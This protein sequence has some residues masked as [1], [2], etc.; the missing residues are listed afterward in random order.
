[1]RPYLVSHISESQP[2]KS[3]LKH[4]SRFLN[5]V[6]ILLLLV[7]TW[8]NAVAATDRRVLILNS[9]HQG[10]TWGDNETSG[11]LATLASASFKTHPEIEYLDTK[12][13]PDQQHFPQLLE[14]YRAKNTLSRIALVLTLDDPAF[15]FAINYRKKLFAG[16]PIVFIG[17]NNFAP[18][19]LKGEEN[20]TGAVE[21]QDF[22]G[23]VAAAL[24]LQPETREV[25]VVHDYTPS[26]L[27]TKQEVMEQLAPLTGRVSVRYL[28]EMTIDE[29]TAALGK[30]HSGSIVLAVSFGVDK[31]GRVFNH[32]ELA[33]ILSEKSPVPVY[34]TKVERL[35]YGIVGGS[36][37]DGRTHGSQG[38]E[39]AL[40]V[41]KQGSAVG[42]P[43]V[44][45]PRSELMFDYRQLSR[46]KIPLNNLPAGSTVINR[47]KSFYSQ[48]RQVINI[49][50]TII[51][52][53]SASLIMVIIA[54][55]RRIK[56]EQELYESRSYQTLF[57][58][59]SD[60]HFIVDKQGRILESSR[61]GQELLQLTAEDLKTRSFQELICKGDPE[62][63]QTCLQKVLQNRKGLCKAAF[64][65]P[66]GET[67]PVEINS[68]LITYRGVEV[69][70]CAARDIRERIHY[71]EKLREL[72]AELEL[73][74][75]DRTL[76]LEISNR[77]LSSF[78]YAIS[79]EMLAPVARLKGFSRILQEDLVESPD[80]ALHC[81]R[82]ITAASNKLE[83]VVAAV[84]QLSRLAQ[85]SFTPMPLNLSRM[86]REI[87]AELEKDLDGRKVDVAIAE[88][89]T[90]IGDPQLMRLCLVNL[91]GNAMKYSALQETAK[92]EFGFD[93]A[94]GAFFVRDNGIGFDITFAD[95]LFEPFIRLHTEEEFAGSGIGLATVQR[96][97]ERH[98]GRIWADA[99]P[100]KGATFFFTLE[101]AKEICS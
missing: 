5:P 73:R 83:Q 30:L 14:L 39:L 22:R 87:T 98:G 40:A 37:M 50:V 99:A 81:A 35:G 96:I 95:R 67:I 45:N 64:I 78:C 86:A 4:G 101:P 12:H 72:N 71:E 76:E 88:G 44:E 33:K 69:I 58:S 93:A 77:D 62:D 75:K 70:L 55:R 84:L 80:E 18:A 1:M 89:I 6:L 11:V 91:L 25:V 9:Y 66:H 8:G 51:S 3:P 57:E 28:P 7:T 17:V 43:V 21:R 85:T 82:R 94:H 92:I 38:A 20:V 26:G 2:E 100:G 53:L 59:A 79:H 27:S 46:F 23:T 52:L 65:Q 63:F 42:V 97:I 48:H 49:S 32:N 19:M 41:L 47:P 74:I 29:V 60:P 36:L 68:T 90:A 16:I 61:A 13:F 34:S 24:A 10:Y 15:D 54:N 56:A 31:A